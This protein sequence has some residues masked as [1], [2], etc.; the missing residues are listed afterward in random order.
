MW[1]VLINWRSKYEWLYCKRM[2]KTSNQHVHENITYEQEHTDVL[3]TQNEP[4]C[5]NENKVKTH[6]H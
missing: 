5:N 2:K 1:G 3:H 4:I 6:Q